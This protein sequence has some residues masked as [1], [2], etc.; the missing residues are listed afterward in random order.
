LALNNNLSLTAWHWKISSWTYNMYVIFRGRYGRDPMVVE[1][2]VQSEPIMT[3]V[4]S[5]NPVHGEMY[6]IQHYLIKFVGDGDL[7]QICGFHRYSGFL[8]QYNWNIV[9]SGIK[10]HKPNQAIYQML[11]GV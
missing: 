1:F 2:R 7:R 11:E 10:H 6:S 8:H 4:V 3:K 9:E 5:L